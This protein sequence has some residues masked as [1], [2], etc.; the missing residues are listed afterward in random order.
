MDELQMKRLKI[1]KFLH[2][3]NFFYFLVDTPLFW[4]K[5]ELQTD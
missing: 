1:S 5:V 3:S 4:T 2:F